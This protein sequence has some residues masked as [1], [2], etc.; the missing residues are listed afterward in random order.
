VAEE[1]IQFIGRSGE[2][3]AIAVALGLIVALGLFGHPAPIAEFVNSDSLLPAHLAWDVAHHSEALRTFQWPRVISLPDIAYFMG[4]QW[5]GLGWRLSYPIYTWLVS[6]VLI[7]A[8]A[9]LV[10]RVRRVEFARALLAAGLLVGAIL[11]LAGLAAMARPDKQ[12]VWMPLLFALVPVTH[13]NGFILSLF[14]ARAALDHA[15]GNRR[16]GTIGL[17]LCAL[18]AFS[19]TLFVLYFLAPFWAATFVS[20]L[21]GRSAGVTARHSGAALRCTIG[22]GLI[23][24]IACLVGWFAQQLVYRQGF[25]EMDLKPVVDNFYS[26]LRNLEFMPWLVPAMALLV[27]VPLREARLLRRGSPAASVERNWLAW[28]GS[29]AALLGLITMVVFQG[30]EA[31]FRSYYTYRY[32]LPLLWWPFVLLLAATPLPRPPLLRLAPVGLAALALVLLPLGPPAILGWRS[33]AE[34][35]VAEHKVQLGLRAG[36]ASYWTARAA[37][38]SS[39]WNTQIDQLSYSGDAYMWGNDVAAYRQDIHDRTRRPA[40]NFLIADATLDQFEL[41]IRYGLEDHRVPCGNGLELLAY[42]RAV[43]PP[44]ADQ[45]PARSFDLLSGWRPG[46]DYN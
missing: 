44:G 37:M 21:T 17:A 26:F 30:E 22:R 36:L 40:Y 38:A 43:E 9:A 12:I 5:L 1:T 29:T 20:E 25:S 13:G 34:R 10:A 7:A 8:I 18:G 24:T 42:N 39:D 16:S 15:D 32:A 14:A 6:L 46:K 19:D 28:F 23:W 35:C 2:L 27:I 33:I 31:D 4:A 45:R 11:L 3:L 41:S